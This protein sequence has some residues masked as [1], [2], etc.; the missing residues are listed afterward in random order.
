MFYGAKE[1]EIKLKAIPQLNQFF[2]ALYLYFLR[3][4]YCPRPERSVIDIDNIH[5][6]PFC[7]NIEFN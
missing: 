1:N 2:Q 3:L 6:F 4:R 5:F 7:E